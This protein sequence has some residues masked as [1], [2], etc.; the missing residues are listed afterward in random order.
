MSQFKIFNP[1]KRVKIGRCVL[2]LLLFQLAA[3]PSYAQQSQTAAATDTT[4][5]LIV[6]GDVDPRIHVELLSWFR[7]TR[8]QSKE[9]TNKQPITGHQQAALTIRG[10]TDLTGQFIAKIPLKITGKDE[11][12]WEYSSTV[13]RMTRALEDRNASY[14]QVMWLASRKSGSHTEAGTGSTHYGSGKIPAA[15][16]ST[17]ANYFLGERIDLQ[18]QTYKYKH[19][20]EEEF[21]CLPQKDID[22]NGGVDVIQTME[23]YLTAQ[24][25]ESQYPFLPYVAP[26]PKSLWQQLKDSWPVQ[27][28][29]N[30]FF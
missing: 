8:L 21:T 28:L 2:A 17:K 23:V 14:T 10:E 5:Y 3:L 4:P 13:L 29:G 27:L 20:G 22:W 6:H 7:S 1:L 25:D 9:C 19:S 11:C 15:E 16:T 12:D 24:V 18:C 30:I 26:P